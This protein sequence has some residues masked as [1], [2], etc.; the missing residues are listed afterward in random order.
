MKM[1]KKL[2]AVVLAGVLA[3]S[4]L[5]GCGDAASTKT[6]A[7]AMS[8]M[9]KNEGIVYKADPKLNEKARLIAEKLSTYEDEEESLAAMLEEDKEEGSEGNL[10][11]E[12]PAIVMD[13]MGS[14]YKDKY[15]WIATTPTK[16]YNV[17]AQAYNLYEQREMVNENTDLHK[18]PAAVR[19]IGTATVTVNGEGYRL[20]VITA[21]AV[22]D[23]V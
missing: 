3:L 15:V 19:Y 16:G 14:D 22:D 8:D 12:I 2:L 13:I 7:D 1:A 9:C 11:E 10:E 18:A 17:T 21:D 20:A 6:I 5:T 4:V 23:K